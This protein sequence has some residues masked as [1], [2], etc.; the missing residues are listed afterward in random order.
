MQ[1]LR[2]NVA[3]LALRVVGALL[4]RDRYGLRVLLI[5][6][7]L[8]SATGLFN[9]FAELVMATLFPVLHLAGCPAVA[10]TTAAAFLAQG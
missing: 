1:G 9:L 3:R 5:C 7:V 10:C 6:V 8:L 2:A 4:D